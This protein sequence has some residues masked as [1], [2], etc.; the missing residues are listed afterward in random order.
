[1]ELEAGGTA[2]A[3]WRDRGQRL[4]VHQI[5][6]RPVCC[7]DHMYASH[8]A[9]AAYRQLTMAIHN[10]LTSSKSMGRAGGG[11]GAGEGIMQISASHYAMQ[12]YAT[13]CM[14]KNAKKRQS[15]ARDPNFHPPEPVAS[16]Y[17]LHLDPH[18]L[19]PS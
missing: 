9:W 11:G 5:E 19:S 15:N 2:W 7:A 10:H 6:F 13:L 3:K 12:T 4:R 16:F 17:L 18:S 8:A 14:C 1:M